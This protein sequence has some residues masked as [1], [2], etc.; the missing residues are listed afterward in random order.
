MGDHLD[1]LLGVVLMAGPVFG[2]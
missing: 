1:L 2:I